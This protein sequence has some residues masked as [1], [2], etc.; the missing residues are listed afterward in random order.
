M[1]SVT[2]MASMEPPV[3]PKG[4]RPMSAA[5]GLDDTTKDKVSYPL[6]ASRKLDGIRAMVLPDLSRGGSPVVVSKSLK[7]IRS[8]YVQKM[9]AKPEYIG[10]DGE[11]IAGSP[12]ASDVFSRSTSAV[13]TIGCQ[14]PV[15]FHTFDLCYPFEE[16]KKP[17][18]QRLEIISKKLVRVVQPVD[19]VIAEIQEGFELVTQYYVHSWDDV[20][21]IESDALELGFEGVMLRRADAPYKNNRSTLREQFLMKLK[22]LQ[23]SEAKIIG[24]V[25]LMTNENVAVIDA[26]GYQKR[27]ASKEGKR[28]ANTLGALIVRD[29]ETGVDFEVGSGFDMAARQFIWD[30]QKNYLGKIITY[31]YFPVGIV[32]K[33]RHPIFKG[34]RHR[35]DM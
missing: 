24:F 14:D 23:D 33:P 18:R 27:S 26:L 6:L 7:P 9:F 13:M 29:I 17:F 11:L 10:L 22:R 8:A 2:S 3:L 31:K 4:F 32:D 1:S 28:G 21:R 35:D 25:E 5:R 34:F 19:D 15:T 30:N 16:A 20:L 12:N